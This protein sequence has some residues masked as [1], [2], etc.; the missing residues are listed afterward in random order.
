V[1]TQIVTV[2]ASFVAYLEEALLTSLMGAAATL[3]DCGWDPQYYATPLR[4][5][6]GYRRL[7]DA[8]GWDKLDRDADLALDLKGNRTAL[9]RSLKEALSL[10]RNLM[11]DDP[12]PRG[13]QHLT[14]RKNA[15]AINSFAA[16]ASL[17]MGR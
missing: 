13:S 2:P 5:F 10:E 17:K 16:T 4:N 3:A 14:A 8:L 7:M 1:A 6:D 9:T 11:A 15:D 12:H